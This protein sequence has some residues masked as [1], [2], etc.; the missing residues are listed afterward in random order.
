MN[1]LQVGFSRLNINPPMG[2]PING[3]YKARHVEGYLDDLE[4]CALAVR[5]EDTA[6]VMLSADICLISTSLMLDLRQKIAKSTNLPLE[7]IWLHT[8]H[9]HTAPQVGSSLAVAGLEFPEQEVLLDEYY[10]FFARRLADAAVMALADCKSAK[11]GWAVGQAPDI[12]FVRR[13]RMKDGKVRTNPGVGNPDI[14]HP[15]G[16]VDERVN[17]LRF[18]RE[19]DTVV[20]A[21][22][23]CHPDTVGGSLSSADWPG[24]AR[25][26]V[27]KA[28][29]NVK[30]IFFNG[31]QGDVNHVKVNA[32]KGDFNDMFNDFDDVARGYGH[33][34][35][36][37]NVVAA[38]VL[39][40]FDKVNYEEADSLRFLQR[41]AKLASNMPT[42]EELPLARKYDALH[43]AGRDD[44]IPFEGME[45]TTVV[46]EAARMLRLEHGPES[47]DLELFGIA[48]GN[49]ALIGIP[50]EPFTGIG[51]GLKE[52][53]DWTLVLP[54]G[55]CNGYQ[56]YF[57][58]K[59][60]YDEGGYEARSSSYRSGV[61]ECI[62]EEGTQLL[63]E[64]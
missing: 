56:G 4:V 64:L 48:L 16:D 58:M 19:N 25:R 7:A 61:A 2:T 22:F 62:I 51:R 40:V 43:Q 13:Y 12:S 34:R 26:R 44:E 45:L 33:A 30:C 24:F 39:Q 50:G 1:K 57:P 38:A 46:A 17:V 5:V 28:L 9:T 27:E 21:N 35:H 37:G 52:A 18:D 11:M 49:I 23:G 15:I 6:A 31:A 10:A 54:V 41:T 47:F 42:A 32:T 20:L 60:A 8:T 36:M 29:D 14:L 55:L 59:D 63:K 3:Y 53:K